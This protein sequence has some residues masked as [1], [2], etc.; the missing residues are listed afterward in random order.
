MFP[1][2]FRRTFG[3]SIC[4]SP[5][6]YWAVNVDWL[7]ISFGEP[8]DIISPPFFPA[9]GP[10]SIRWSARN[11][12]SLSCSTTKTEFPKSRSAVNESISLSLSL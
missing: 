2:P 10:M 12:M 1:F 5:V 11:I 8:C 3:I 9:K 7:K 4:N 6:K